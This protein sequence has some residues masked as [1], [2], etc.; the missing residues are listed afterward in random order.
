MIRSFALTSSLCLAVLATACVPPE[1]QQPPQEKI[2]RAIPSA[3]AVQIKLPQ[4]NVQQYTLGQVADTYM[5]TRAITTGFNAG[6]AWVLIVV[7]AVVQTP[8]TS[9]DGDTYVW[10]PGS[11]PLDPADYRLTVV[12]NGD[13]SYSWELAGQSKSDP[14]QGF[15]SLIN[16][17]AVPGA[18]P[19]HGTGN[20]SI[21]FDNI[22]TV[23]PID[24]P[25][26]RGSVDVEYDLENRDGTQ[27][28]LAMHIES[29]DDGGEPVSADYHYGENLDGSGDFVFSVQ[30]DIDDNGSAQEQARIR[31]R[32]QNDGAGRADVQASGGDLGADS[33]V[34]SQCW[35]TQFLSVYEDLF[36]STGDPQA[37]VFSDLDLPGA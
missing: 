8:P 5:W 16:G 30:T 35:D 4:D 24:N 34:F 9:V 36:T 21:N 13:G 10:G 6:A 18:E 33:L 15:L 1:E 27:A 22:H 19:Q 28:T 32:W 12:D 23:D 2:D 31:S 29:T 17:V 37:C 20:F 26:A 7:H 14:Q 25:D 3:D 11:K